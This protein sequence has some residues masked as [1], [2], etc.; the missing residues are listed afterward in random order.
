MTKFFFK[1]GLNDFLFF[2]LVIKVMCLFF[3]IIYKMPMS[4]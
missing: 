1:L 3:L 2:N 4:F